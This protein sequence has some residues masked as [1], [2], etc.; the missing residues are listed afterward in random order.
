MILAVRDE[1]RGRRAAAEMR[2]DVEVR[3][4]DLANLVC[5]RIRR[6]VAAAVDV[7]INNAGI[8]AVPEGRTADG[9]ELQFATNHLGPFADEPAPAADHRSFG[10]CLVQCPSLR[11]PGS[12]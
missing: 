5:A 11:G 4:L 6:G 3:H 8:M 1:D 7:L 9:F 10:D 12:R 2:G